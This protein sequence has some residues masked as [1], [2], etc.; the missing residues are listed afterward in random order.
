MLLDNARDK[1]A[2]VIEEI[3]VKELIWDE[4]KVVGVRART[5]DGEKQIF[6][7]S[8]LMPQAKRHLLQRATVGANETLI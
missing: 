2:E 5:K 6:V 3:A 1:G 7:R 4:D 8:P